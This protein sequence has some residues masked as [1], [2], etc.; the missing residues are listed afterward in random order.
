M[1]QTQFGP[2]ATRAAVLVVL[3][4]AAC[5]LA[6]EAAPDKLTQEYARAITQA[7]A[8][9]DA[10]RVTEARQRLDATDKALR[11]FEFEYLLARAQAAPAKGA[12]PDLIRTLATPKVETR[13][14]V[15]NELDRQLAFICRDGSVRVHDLNAPE[16]APKTL[17]HEG[18]GAIWTGAFSHDGKTFVAGHENG[19]V[20]VRDAKTWKVRHTVSL[21]E[22]WPVREL[23]VAP[24]GSA[25]VAEGKAALELWSLAEGKPKK[26]A[27]VGER[28]NFGEGLAFSPK[29]DLIATGGMFDIILHKAATGEQTK[30][31]RH[32]SYT[33]GLEFSPDGKRIA[34]APRANVNKFL[35][36][37]DVADAKPVFTAGPFTEYVAGLAFTPDGKRVA[38]TGP[39]RNVRLFDAATGVVVLTLSRTDHTAKP[40]V[41]RDGRLLG[42]S[43]PGG[44]R[45][46]DL[47]KKPDG[48]R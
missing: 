44:Y 41:S 26:V 23:A 15:L 4:L 31:M 1:T 40:A 20:V 35:S 18:A 21:G 48:G 47:G 22:K 34:S 19:D 42:W 7:Q 3:G 39:Q 5:G 45:Y 27:A 6:Q 8:D 33:M 30:S 14:A 16:A 9:L 24:D 46:I 2:R 32:A 11:S 25:F 12:A 43:E 29:G 13:Y 38:A 17:T 28:Y 36:V 37:F 10:G